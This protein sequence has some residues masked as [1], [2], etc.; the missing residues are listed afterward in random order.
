AFINEIEHRISDTVRKRLPVARNMPLAARVVA[1]DEVLDLFLLHGLAVDVQHA[2]DHLDLIAGKTDHALD[3]IRLVVTR[4]LEDDD[5]AA[6]GLR[7]PDATGEQVRSEWEGVAAI[8]VAVFRHEK[9]VA[10]EERRDHRSGGDIEGL[11][12]EDAYDQSEDQRMND[13]A[14]RIFET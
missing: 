9:V 4:Q 3:V 6:R 10:D 8:A 11:K 1:H 2:V 12:E 13:D 7:A 14:D 5:V